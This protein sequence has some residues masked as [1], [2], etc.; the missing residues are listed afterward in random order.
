VKASFLMG[1]KGSESRRFLPGVSINGDPSADVEEM[2]RPEMLSKLLCLLLFS[3]VPEFAD[4]RSCSPRYPSFIAMRKSG[5]SGS[6]SS[7]SSC[8]D[9]S[10]SDSDIE[11]VRCL[12]RSALVV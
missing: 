6:V 1:L 8:S 4:G 9:A 11:S 12:C 5:E 7:S 3:T 2:G 10:P